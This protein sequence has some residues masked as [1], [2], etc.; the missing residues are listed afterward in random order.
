ML[1]RLDEE[2]SARDFKPFTY[3]SKESL[4]SLGVISVPL[5]FFIPWDVKKQVKV[6]Q[7]ELGWE[8]NDV[9]GVSPGYEYEKIECYLQ[10]VRD[11]IKFFEERLFKSNS[12]NV[13]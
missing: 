7:E 10:G 1:I 9:E 13:K 6:I 4:S 12:F 3:P 5:G 11:Y 2:Y 8:G